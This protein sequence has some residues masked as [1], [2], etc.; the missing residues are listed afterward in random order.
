MY[1]NLSE[2]HTALKIPNLSVAKLIAVKA[3][4]KVSKEMHYSHF[5]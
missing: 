3:L 1:H 5:K 2:L 4:Y